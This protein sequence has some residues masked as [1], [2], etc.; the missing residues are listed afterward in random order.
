MSNL[1]IA[2]QTIEA[3]LKHV[4]QGIAFYQTKAA[5]LQAALEHIEYAE[6]GSR[7]NASQREAASIL[8]SG[9]VAAAPRKRGRKSGTRKAGSKLPRMTRSYWMDFISHEPKTAVDIVNAA[10][11]SFDTELE[12]DQVKKMK[13]RSTQALQALLGSKQIKDVGSG[14]QR[15]YFLP[16]GK[17]ASSEKSGSK[18]KTSSLDVGTT[19]LH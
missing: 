15:R 2:R 17:S 14:R 7:K 1:K 5:A 8:Y 6:S 10:I 19:I 9:P 16:L 3:E 11:A 4:E 18:V 12:P 13:Q